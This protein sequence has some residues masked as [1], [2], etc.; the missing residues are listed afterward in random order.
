MHSV[1]Y[2]SLDYTFTRTVSFLGIMK[3]RIHEQSYNPIGSR[4][5]DELHGF[6]SLPLLEEC[7]IEHE[8]VPFL[9]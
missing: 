9:K 6:A 3:I 8:T 2:P 7:G 1:E 4:L 5:P